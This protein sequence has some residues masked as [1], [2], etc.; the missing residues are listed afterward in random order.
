MQLV[1]IRIGPLNAANSLFCRC[2]ALPVVAVEVRIFFEFRIVVG[3]QHLTV[4]V[5]VDSGVFA[6]FK[7]LFQVAEVVAGDENARRL[8]AP[9]FTCVTCGFP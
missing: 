2:Q 7:Q 3:R 1:V 8:P 6:L 9:V 5:D 4:G